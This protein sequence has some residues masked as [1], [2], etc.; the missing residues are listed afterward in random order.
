MTEQRM[1]H[2]QP[3]VV[4]RMR[5]LIDC[6]RPDVIQ[7]HFGIGLNTWVKVREGHAIRHSVAQRLLE[8]LQRDRII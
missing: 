1:T 5:S 7:R 4:A 6:Q 8:R 2:V 3:D